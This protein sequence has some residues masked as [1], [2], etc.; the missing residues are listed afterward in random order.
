MNNEFLNAF[1]SLDSILNGKSKD[2]FISRFRKLCESDSRLK[3]YLEYIPLLND[4]RNI[5]AHNLND[6]KFF[7][8]NEYSIKILNEIINIIN[9]PIK[10]ISV[11]IKKEDYLK[12]NLEIRF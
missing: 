5:R 6:E 9:F 7:S 12:Q 11:S 3:K 1:R 8:V 2:E 4:V 10:A